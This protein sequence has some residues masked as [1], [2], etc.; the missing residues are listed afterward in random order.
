[1]NKLDSK[2]NLNNYQVDKLNE[3]ETNNFNNKNIS[4]EKEPKEIKIEQSSSNSYEEIENLFVDF[5]EYKNKYLEIK[6]NKIENFIN[7]KDINDKDK[8]IQFLESEF[9][10]LEEQQ[11]AI[12][13]SNEE[14]NKYYDNDKE[15][16]E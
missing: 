8:I 1:M 14:M 9:Y 16:A 6:K 15:I 11:K 12:Y 4:V 7:N 2:E 10:F 5:E 13:Y 3:S